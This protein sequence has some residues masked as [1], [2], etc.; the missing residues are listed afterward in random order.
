MSLIVSP[1]Q[2]KLTTR[3]EVD[4]KRSF[5]QPQ[6]RR[7]GAW[8]FL[9]LFG[10]T[11]QVDGMVV[12]RHPHTGLQTVTWPFSGLMEHRDSVGSIQTLKPGELNLMTA[13]TGIS[14]SEISLVGPSSL[15]AAQ[16]WVALPE[17]SR[18]VEPSFEHHAD[19]P[20]VKLG[21]STAKVFIG[22]FANAQSQAKVYSPLVG[23]ELQVSGEVGLPLTPSFEHGILVVSGSMNVNGQ[24]VAVDELIY[25]PVGEAAVISGN[26]V[27]LLLG[28]EPFTEHIVMWWNFIGR[29]HAEI[30]SWRE[31]WN[32]QEEQWSDFEDEVGSW[33][34]APELPNVTLNPRG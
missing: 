30:V 16:L 13:G 33:I 22:R 32:S 20:M 29:S 19:L 17:G 11:E 8:V 23:V 7:I 2:V 18:E 5:P 28:G 10:P 12:A 3:T 14:H 1:R 15:H 27:A 21:D 24:P 4:I 34:P 6:L 9:D 25:L 31:A 26:G